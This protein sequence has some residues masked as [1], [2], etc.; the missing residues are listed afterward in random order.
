MGFRRP[1]PPRLPLASAAASDFAFADSR[2]PDGASAAGGGVRRRRRRR[3]APE[4][5]TAARR[6]V[7]SEGSAWSAAAVVRHAARLAAGC[8]R[9][10]AEVAATRHALWRAA[11]RCAT[12]FAVPFAAFSKAEALAVVRAFGQASVRHQGFLHNVAKR[13]SGAYSVGEVAELVHC[14]TR[15]RTALPLTVLTAASPVVG[16]AVARAAPGGKPKVRR[17][18]GGDVA[19]RH[20]RMV[21]AY[22]SSVYETMYDGVPADA[23][24]RTRKRVEGFSVLPLELLG[25]AVAY[26]ERAG[27]AGAA[28]EADAAADAEGKHAVRVGGLFALAVASCR[29][30]PELLGYRRFVENRQE[31]LRAAAA[32]LLARC[33]ACGRGAAAAAD[34][35]VMAEAALLRAR[36][37][38]LV[39]AVGEAACP[40]HRPLLLALAKAFVELELQMRQMAADGVAAA[41]EDRRPLHDAGVVLLSVARAVGTGQ[42]ACAE[43]LPARWAAEA[44]R[45]D[46]W[47][48]SADALVQSALRTREGAR[49]TEDRAA[50]VCLW[51]LAVLRTQPGEASGSGWTG[52]FVGLFGK[53]RTRE[54]WWPEVVCVWWSFYEVH[55][56]GGGGGG[57]GEEG[58]ALAKAAARFVQGAMVTVVTMSRNRR[59]TRDEAV[60]VAAVL[61]RYGM[62]EERDVLMPYLR[63]AAGGGEPVG[64]V[65]RPFCPYQFPLL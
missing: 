14:H 32:E 34:R 56:G 40:A 8:R 36:V 35:V 11:E 7:A 58:A 25:P 52:Q 27:A 39:R 29:A 9:D 17:T 50:V 51:A 15:I 53:M 63:T 10:G 3:R 65:I 20:P 48:L 18:V 19:T 46:V 2:S 31:L 37:T 38:L 21:L 5:S 54:L 24:D 22:L 62:A 23:A 61:E 28:A 16:G 49:A 6:W 30:G 60:L 57:G 1:P 12:G 47:P 26:A 45:V 42:A 64:P 44:A 33:R 43:Y 59:V 4:P 13:H 41:V 55:G